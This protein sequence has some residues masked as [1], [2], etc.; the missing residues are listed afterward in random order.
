[1]SDQLFKRENDV[2]AEIETLLGDD[3]ADASRYRS[4]LNRYC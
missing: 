4:E 3:A 2:I 1:M